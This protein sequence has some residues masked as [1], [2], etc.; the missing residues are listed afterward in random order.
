MAGFF[1]DFLCLRLQKQNM[2][3]FLL[4]VSAAQPA[5]GA[6]KLALSETVRQLNQPKVILRRQIK[7]F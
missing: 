7:P 4:C 5:F 6:F 1:A 3:L 2:P